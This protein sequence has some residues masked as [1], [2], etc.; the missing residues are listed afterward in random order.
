LTGERLVG[1]GEA[2]PWS[3]ARELAWAPAGTSVVK[4][5]TTPGRI[6]D[7]EAALAP[8]GTTRRYSVG[9]HLCWIAWPPGEPL[10]SLDSGL[11]DLGACGVR[12]TGPPG[13]PLLLGAGGGAEFAARARRGL[14]PDRVFAE[15]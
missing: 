9:G 15:L 2:E 10:A 8:A 13:P 12:L 14:D 5:A 1:P 6:G 11:A 4:V 7:L 3:A